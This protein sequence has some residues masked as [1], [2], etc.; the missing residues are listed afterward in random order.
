MRFF[1]FFSTPQQPERVRRIGVQ[2]GLA[3]NDPEVKLRLGAFLPELQRLGWT[4][5]RN[6]RIDIRGANGNPAVARKQ[7]AEL[8]ALEPD[9]ILA[10][11]NLPMPPLVELTHTIPIVFAIVMDPV[12]AGFVKN[13]SRPG[14]NVTGFMMFEYSLSGKW[15][16]LLKQI[17]LP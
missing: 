9:I 12:G 16:E 11:G 7:A 13:L 5:G 2:T 14:G 17:A 8:I 10:I 15:L 4:E 6:L 1:F 3:E